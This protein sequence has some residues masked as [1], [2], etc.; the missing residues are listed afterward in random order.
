M[1]VKKL[2]TNA[3]ITGRPFLGTTK[4]KGYR[5]SRKLVKG[6]K[7]K[8]Q[9]SECPEVRAAGLDPAQKYTVEELSTE[10]SGNT[11]VALQNEEGGISKVLLYSDQDTYLQNRINAYT[12]Q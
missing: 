2:Y 10:A 5:Y 6:L 12:K 3:P 11:L 9:F 4:Q 8:I 1:A 7:S